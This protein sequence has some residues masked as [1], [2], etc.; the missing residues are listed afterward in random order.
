M[1]IVE[2]VPFRSANLRAKHFESHGHEFGATDEYD[3]E[4]MADTFMSAPLEPPTIECTTVSR[5][6]D[7]IRLEPV[8]RYFGVETTDPFIKTFMIKNEFNIAHRGGSEAFMEYKR[9]EIRN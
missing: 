9:T 8:T 4:R 1:Y 5:P 6:F 3:Y 7:R 2:T